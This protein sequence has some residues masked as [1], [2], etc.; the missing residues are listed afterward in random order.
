MNT[1]NFVDY[2]LSFIWTNISFTTP[3]SYE[4]C[5]R[6]YISSLFCPFIRS[7]VRLSARPFVNLTSKFCNKTFSLLISVTTFQILITFS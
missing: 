1:Y 7:F 4:V 3:P 6:V 2:L 5:H